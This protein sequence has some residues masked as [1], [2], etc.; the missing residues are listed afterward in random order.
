MES[1]SLFVTINLFDGET[2]NYRNVHEVSAKSNFL[3][4][5]LGDGVTHNIA[6]SRIAHYQVVPM[7]ER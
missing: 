2:R 1:S 7:E 5:Y 6:L 4:V 3:V